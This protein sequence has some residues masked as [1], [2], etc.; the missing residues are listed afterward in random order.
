MSE[1]LGHD[2]DV[3]ARHRDRVAAAGSLARPAHGL[4]GGAGATTSS[5]LEAAC[6]E[7]PAVGRSAHV[8]RHGVRHELRRVQVDGRARGGARPSIRTTSGRSSNTRSCTTGS[9]RLP[10]AEEEAAKARRSGAERAGSSRSPGSSCRRSARLN[11]DSTRNITLDKPLDARRPWCWS[12]MM[13]LM[14]VGMAWGW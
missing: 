10:C 9:A 12:A 1:A 7:Q 4:A 11:R 8:P 2:D 6:L 14:F 5:D 3:A 13:L